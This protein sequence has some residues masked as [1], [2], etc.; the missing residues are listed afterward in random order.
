MEAN[1]QKKKTKWIRELEI[2]VM[3]KIF[4]VP[5]QHEEGLIVVG[6][7]KMILDDCTEL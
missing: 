6:Q 4:A 2:D 7:E 1:D 3:A 5:K